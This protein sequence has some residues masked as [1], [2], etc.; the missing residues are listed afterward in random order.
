[1]WQWPPQRQVA[2]WDI[3]RRGKGP[4]PALAWAHESRTQ[5][6]RCPPA[7]V[8]C[9]MQ[10]PSEAGLGAAERLGRGPRLACGGGWDPLRGDPLRRHTSPA[11]FPT[12][13]EPAIPHPSYSTWM[14][15]HC[16][17]AVYLYCQNI[18]YKWNFSQHCCQVD[19][20]G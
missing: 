1:M 16:G 4:W 7:Q 3:P 12:W 18:T 14:L 10:Q 15:L 9:F 5:W 20:G 19:S 17:H 13:S 8:L 6:S 11:I 2:P